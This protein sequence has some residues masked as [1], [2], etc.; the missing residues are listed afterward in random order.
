MPDKPL[1]DEDKALFREHVRDVQPLH[2]K[3]QI[4]PSNKEKPVASQK[5]IPPL[6][7]FIQEEVS[8]ET[9]LSYRE[10]SVSHLRFKALQKGEIPWEARLDLHGKTT[11][12]A[13]VALS[14]FLSNQAGK[15]CLLIVHGKGGYHGVP[16]VIKNLVNRWLPQF[17]EVLAYHSAIPKDGGTGA[18]YVLLKKNPLL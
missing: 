13:R 3:E 7:D 18:V 15:K 5:P 8:S 10:K 9:I 4:K 2:S 12:E 11:E 6:S 14:H 17:E 16:P 1:S